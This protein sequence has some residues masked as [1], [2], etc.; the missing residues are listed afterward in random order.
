MKNFL[1]WEFGATYIR[2]FTVVPDFC[3]DVLHDISSTH[4]DKF[5]FITFSH[6]YLSQL[7]RLFD[8]AFYE[9]CWI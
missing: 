5:A 4:V 1:V 6:K 2:D 9:L 7:I 8:T 3:G